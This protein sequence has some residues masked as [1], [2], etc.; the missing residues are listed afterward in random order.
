MNLNGRFNI[1]FP[2]GQDDLRRGDIQGTINEETSDLRLRSLHFHP[3][4]E[5]RKEYPGS[6]AKWLPDVEIKEEGLSN[7]IT[8]VTAYINIGSF[9]NDN[10]RVRY[11]PAMFHKWMTVF[12]RIENPVVAYMT[13]DIDIEI[14]KSIRANI[15][16]APTKVIKVSKDSLW[17]FSM[18]NDI[19]KIF[20]DPK[21]PKHSPNTFVADYSC[22]MHAKYELVA[23]TIQSNPFKSKYMAWIDIGYFRQLSEEI[24]GTRFVLAL[25]P[26]FDPNR[27]SYEEVFHFLSHTEDEIFKKNRVWVT[28]SFFLSKLSTLK[29]WILEYSWYTEK[30]LQQRL[31]NTDQ[32]IIYAMYFRRGELSVDIQTYTWQGLYDPWFQLGFLC[33]EQGDKLKRKKLGLPPLDEAIDVTSEKHLQKVIDI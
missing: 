16:S 20:N 6:P 29:Q 33:R 30:Y 5:D 17:A 31:M 3:A 32:Q 26:K 18:K 10:L 9:L 27:V 2:D 21:Y 24:N 14:F 22:T 4:P 12:S 8:L 28:G 15:S 1:Q 11:E 19:Q 23:K 7:D 25:P 13:E